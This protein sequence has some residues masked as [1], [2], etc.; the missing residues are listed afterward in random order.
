MTPPRQTPILSQACIAQRYDV[1]GW[2]PALL[3][4]FLPNHEVGVCAA[5]YGAEPFR[6]SSV[7]E[8]AGSVWL[9]GVLMGG[10]AAP[11]Q[12]L[13][14]DGYTLRLAEVGTAL[15]VEVAQD[16][17]E[18]VVFGVHTPAG[19]AAAVSAADASC[20]EPHDPRTLPVRLNVSAL[21]LETVK[22][23]AVPCEH[24]GGGVGGPRGEAH[25]SVGLDAGVSA[26]AAHPGPCP[27]LTLL[28]SRCCW[29]HVR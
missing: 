19:S 7:A 22:G 25:T 27:N 6:A 4:A 9:T 17:S 20:I 5:A 26:D 16:G 21:T 29:A 15:G 2:D 24:A 23:A 14:V 13:L 1:E 3:G 8:T 12:T 18:A 28:P 11:P 10:A